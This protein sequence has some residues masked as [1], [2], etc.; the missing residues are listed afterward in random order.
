MGHPKKH[1][2][3]TGDDK[4]KGHTIFAHGGEQQQY[5]ADMA[6]GQPKFQAT[7]S[8][9]KET[10][11]RKTCIL[12]IGALVNPKF[13]LKTKKRFMQAKKKESGRARNMKYVKF[14]I[15]PVEPRDDRRYHLHTMYPVI[16]GK[17]CTEMT[18]SVPKCR[19][20]YPVP[21]RRMCMNGKKKKN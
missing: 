2:T 1:L 6:I 9:A 11:L 18:D 8:E 3:F 4:G 15:D 12:P 13:A 21:E 17:I 19:S 5:L 16:Q 20:M 10:N 14:V 7:V